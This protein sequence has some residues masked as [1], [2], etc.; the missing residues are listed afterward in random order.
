MIFFKDAEITKEYGTRVEDE[1]GRRAEEEKEQYER[2][3]SWLNNIF[4]N[5]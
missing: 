2:T 4:K 1:Y 5:F 3:S